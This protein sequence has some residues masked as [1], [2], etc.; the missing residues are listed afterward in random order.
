MKKSMKLCR[1]L[2]FGVKSVILR[3]SKYAWVGRLKG[4]KAYEYWG[5]EGCLWIWKI[6]PKKFE[7]CKLAV[8]GVQTKLPIHR[9]L[10]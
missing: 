10:T 9:R 4:A 7:R 5:S 3:F 2:D 6:T 8:F 1:G